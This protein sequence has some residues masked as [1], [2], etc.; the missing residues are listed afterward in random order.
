MASSPRICWELHRNQWMK[1]MDYCL[2][3]HVDRQR[4]FLGFVF[5]DHP[6]GGARPHVLGGCRGGQKDENGKIE[7][8][9][10]HVTVNELLS[11]V[12]CSY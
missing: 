12:E 6:E 9:P 11:A 3:K 1:L 10:Y 2:Q 7:V 5:T 4:G 8:V